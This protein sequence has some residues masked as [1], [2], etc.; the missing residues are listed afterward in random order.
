MSPRRKNMEPRRMK[1]TKDDR[2]NRQLSNYLSNGI[3]NAEM[4]GTCNIH[5]S[6]RKVIQHGRNKQA[7]ACKGKNH[8]IISHQG[9]RG[10]VEV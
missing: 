4:D 7:Q 10:E 9:P 3:T 6:N 8:H 2:N 5:E 1:Y